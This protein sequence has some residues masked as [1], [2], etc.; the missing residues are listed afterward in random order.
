[1]LKKYT[2]PILIA[3]LLLTTVFVR[4]TNA[5]SKSKLGPSTEEI[6]ASILKIGVGETARVEVKLRD[7][8]RVK[9]YVY[10][11]GKDNF[12]VRDSKTGA[13]TTIPYSEVSAVKGKG[14]SKGAKIAIGVGIGL[15]AAI[16]VA[17]ILVSRSMNSGILRGSR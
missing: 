4:S 9:G 15:A 1:M 12:I 6:K 7:N 13:D 11:A 2:I 10:Q 8:K 16:A 17:A 14:M 3:S 5:S